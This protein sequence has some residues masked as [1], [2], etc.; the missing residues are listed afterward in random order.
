MH[1]TRTAGS[2]QQQADASSTRPCMCLKWLAQ[3]AHAH[4]TQTVSRP[5]PCSK[6]QMSHTVGL[7]ESACQIPLVGQQPGVLMLPRDMELISAHVEDAKFSMFVFT[8]CDISSCAHACRMSPARERVDVLAGRRSP[9]IGDRASLI[10][11]APFSTI[12]FGRGER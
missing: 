12:F 2:W 6:T 7:A 8:S 11:R 1:L 4:A 10:D 9:N 3:S 5:T